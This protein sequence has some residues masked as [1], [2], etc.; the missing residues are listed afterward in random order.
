[1]MLYFMFLFV[2]DLIIPALIASLVGV[3]SIFSGIV[4]KKKSS[5]QRKK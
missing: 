5:N 3:T 4:R 2:L 1:M